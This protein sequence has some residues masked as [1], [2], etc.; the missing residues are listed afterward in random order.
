MFATSLVLAV[1][2]AVA[3]AIVAFRLRRASPDL[4]AASDAP[5]GTEYWPLWTLA[6]LS[7]KL[8]R[9]LPPGLKPVAVV[10]VA[11]LV[12]SVTLLVLLVVRF[13]VNVGSL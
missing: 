4:H 1:I 8:W 13:V 12:A 9:Q 10:A 2:A 5:S 3:G 6:L 7:P 11:A